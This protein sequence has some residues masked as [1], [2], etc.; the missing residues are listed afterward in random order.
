MSDIWRGGSIGTISEQEV[1]QALAERLGFDGEQLADFMG[2][3]W[4]EYLG[5]ANTELIDYAVGCARGTAPGS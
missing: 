2:D 4:R 5:T 1:H 3:I